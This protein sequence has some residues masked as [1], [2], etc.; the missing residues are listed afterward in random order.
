MCSC[1]SFI[2]FSN[3]LVSALWPGG[4]RNPALILDAVPSSLEC[5]RAENER[6]THTQS[7][8]INLNT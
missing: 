2:L 3:G 1:S 5:V 6:F 7:R 4:Q 8:E